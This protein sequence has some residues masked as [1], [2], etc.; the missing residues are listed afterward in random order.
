MRAESPEPPSCR[1]RE[2]DDGQPGDIV[3]GQRAGSLG[4]ACLV[5][6]ACEYSQTRPITK[7]NKNDREMAGAI[8]V[9]CR[10]HW[11]GGHCSRPTPRL[12]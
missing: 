6:D 9:R 11:L 8:T 12:C 7:E 2:D 1:V 3:V 4:A 10:F 5:F